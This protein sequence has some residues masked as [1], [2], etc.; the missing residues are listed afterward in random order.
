MSQITTKLQNFE[1]NLWGYHFPIPAKKGKK[2]VDGDNRRI[3]CTINNGYRLQ[4]ALM[5]SKEG[6]FILINKELVK[7]LNLVIDE[8]VELKLEKDHSEFGHEVP[9]SFQALLEQ[10][11]EGKAYFELLTMGKQRSLIYIVKKVKNIDSQVNKGMAIL[12]HLK[13]AKGKLDFR[14][15]NQLIKDYNQKNRLK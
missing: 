11:H 10:D 2:Y 12:D 14:A 7:K 1:S 15:L 9:E 6:Y 8:E 3:I 4:C 5:S 13:M